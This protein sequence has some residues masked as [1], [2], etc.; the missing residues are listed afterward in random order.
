MIAV[1][2]VA[3]IGPSAAAPPRADAYVYWIQKSYKADSQAYV[4]RANLDGSHVE[5]RFIATG[6]S[7]G[8]T[9][10][11]FTDESYVYWGG[12]A[13]TVAGD[14]VVEGH[15]VI[16]RANR[17]GSGV[18]P[19]FMG[20]ALPPFGDGSITPVGSA[21]GGAVAGPY[22]YWANGFSDATSG[23]V[24][25]A[26]RDGTGVSPGFILPGTR[27]E[28]IAVT[29]TAIYW[30]GH[31]GIGRANL[32]GTGVDPGFIT[33]TEAAD[34]VAVTGTHI[35]WAD[36]GAGKDGAIGRARLDGTDVDYTFVGRA[37]Q[38]QQVVV[39]GR[40]LYYSELWRKSPDEVERRITRTTLEGKRQRSLVRGLK[41]GIG[42]AVD[43]QGPAPAAR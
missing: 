36:M 22:L 19:S 18:N 32:D 24:G 39:Y 26:N 31:A 15:G 20:A 11:L 23:S 25:R 17:D 21:C 43:G 8:Y 38:P 3:A 28:A 5:R 4:A 37:F 40:H 14:A 34:S 27:P 16:G 2:A 29:P 41:Q 42:L 12:H 33:G 13:V 7:G 10:G 1:A 6:S 30:A 35:Y 9:C